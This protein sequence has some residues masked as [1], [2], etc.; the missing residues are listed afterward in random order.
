MNTFSCR[1]RAGRPSEDTHPGEQPRDANAN[2]GGGVQE[3]RWKPRPVALSLATV[4][5]PPP[6]RVG[7]HR[8]SET[9]KSLSQPIRG[10]LSSVV[11]HCG[12]RLCQTLPEGGA[13]SGSVHIKGQ[14]R[15]LT[16][17]DVSAAKPPT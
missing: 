16:C 3:E 1:R 17:H 14:I 4:R 11:A 8:T 2:G 7:A 10:E 9:G 12:R 5:T 13:L 6:E 15:T